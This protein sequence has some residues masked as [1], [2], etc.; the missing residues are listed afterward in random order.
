MFWNW[1]IMWISHSNHPLSIQWLHLQHML[2]FVLFCFVLFC[3]ILLCFVVLFCFA[4][5]LFF[6][7]PQHLIAIISFL[8]LYYDTF[9]YLKLLKHQNDHDT[10]LP[11]VRNRWLFFKLDISCENQSLIFQSPTMNPMTYLQHMCC[12]FSR[13]HNFL[14][15]QSTFYCFIMTQLSTCYCPKCWRANYYN[16]YFC[17][18][19]KKWLKHFNLF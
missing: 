16:V 5:L 7:I 13:Y 14:L 11:L 1:H 3:F 10:S 18:F 6:K 4:L 17:Y 12:L 2:F 19:N 8:L 15:Q 9:V